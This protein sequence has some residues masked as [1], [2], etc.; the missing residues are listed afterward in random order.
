MAYALIK[1]KC[2]SRRPNC[3]NCARV[4]ALAVV[5]SQDLTGFRID[6]V[7]P[8]ADETG[9]R[10]IGVVVAF[11]RIIGDPTLNAKPGIRTAVE[12]S[13]HN[14]RPSRGRCLRAT[15]VRPRRPLTL[16][17]RLL[18]HRLT[19]CV[20]D[21]DQRCQKKIARRWAEGGHHRAA[22]GGDRAVKLKIEHQGTIFDPINGPTHRA[23]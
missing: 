5:A 2:Q 13:A 6:Q 14:K 16:G 19:R 8:R 23:R 17:A 3:Q 21:M 11:R 9:Y 22:H 15:L 10:L 12:K 1:I 7:Y 18:M 4:Q 20:L